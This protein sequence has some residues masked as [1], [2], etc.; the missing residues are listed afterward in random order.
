[1]PTEFWWRGYGS[2]TLKWIQVN[3]VVRMG[4]EWSGYRSYP[5]VGLSRSGSF[6]P[7][8]SAATV[9]VVSSQL[10]NMEYYYLR[11]RRS[12]QQSCFLFGGSRTQTR[13]KSVSEV[14]RGFHHLLL[15]QCNLKE[16]TQLFLHLFSNLNLNYKVNRLVISQIVH[17]IHPS[18]V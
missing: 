1:M 7:S 2:V 13:P 11:A 14:F 5:R 6:A 10:I 17:F 12:C 8:G 4:G 16:T 3:L 9:S 18:W 15:W